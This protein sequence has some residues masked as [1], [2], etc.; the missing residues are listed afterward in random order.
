MNAILVFVMAQSDL[1]LD[2]EIQWFYLRTP[3]QNLYAWYRDRFLVRY[4]GWDWGRFLWAVTK[5]VAWLAIS[6]GLFEAKIFWKL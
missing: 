3:E 2:T 5:V 6:V 4:L 1:G